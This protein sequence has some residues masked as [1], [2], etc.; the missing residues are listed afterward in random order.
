MGLK[1]TNYKVNEFDIT[2]DTAYAQI[3]NLNV[4]LDGEAHCIFEIQKDRESIGNKKYFE[5]KIFNCKIDKTLPIYEQIYVAAKEDIFAG[6]EDD[7]IFED[8]E[9]ETEE[10]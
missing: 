9:Q 7:I 4:S 3:S 1:T 6:W 8:K 5:T 10:E 2:L